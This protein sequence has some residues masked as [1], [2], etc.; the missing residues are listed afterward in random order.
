MLLVTLVLRLET[1]MKQFMPGTTLYVCGIVVFVLLNAALTHAG[2]YDT[3]MRTYINLCIWLQRP[4][5]KQRRIF[6]CCLNRLRC[7]RGDFELKSL[8]ASRY[9]CDGLETSFEI[10]DAPGRS[11]A[12]LRGGIL[13]RDQQG[14]VCRSGRHRQVLV[15]C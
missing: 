13:R 6:I 15:S 10:C 3:L 14:Y 11:H 4:L 7:L 9:A 8:T 12:P 5:L 1:A 2:K